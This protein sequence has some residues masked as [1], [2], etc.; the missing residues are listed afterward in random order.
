MQGESAVSAFGAC[1]PGGSITGAPKTR[2]MQIIADV[3]GAGR[4]VYCGSLGYF[5]ADGAAMFSI[6]IRTVTVV[7]GWATFSAGGGVVLDSDP[8]QEYEETLAKAAGLVRALNASGGSGNGGSGGSGCS[9]SGGSDGGIDGERD[10][11][12]T[13]GEKRSR[14]AKVRL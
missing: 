1:F 11:R 3:E 9:G 2:A 8:V 4:G 5:A 10:A 7:G 12:L 14:V 6:A 13:Q